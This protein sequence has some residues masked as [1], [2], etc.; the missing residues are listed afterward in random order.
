MADISVTES[1]IKLHLIDKAK[2]FGFKAPRV[3]VV[4]RIAIPNGI[5]RSVTFALVVNTDN[6]ALLDALIADALLEHRFDYNFKSSELNLQGDI[7][8]DYLFFEANITA[9][10]KK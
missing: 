9:K 10:I 4:E 6:E 1:D 2:A 7:E 8:L 5:T 3:L